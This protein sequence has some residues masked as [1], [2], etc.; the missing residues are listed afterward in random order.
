MSN[1]KEFIN[2]PYE[3]VDEKIINYYDFEEWI[4]RFNLE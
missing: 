1:I 4:K 3:Y 2:S